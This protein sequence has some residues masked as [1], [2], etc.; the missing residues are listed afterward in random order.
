MEKEEIVRMFQT[1]NR[2]ICCPKCGAKYTFDNIKIVNSEDNL[3]FVS[4][5]C[6]DHPPVLAS[7]VI[8]QGKANDSIKQAEITPDDVIK[9][10]IGLRKVKSIKDLIYRKKTRR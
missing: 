8:Y 5:R 3:F 1:I 9:S 7:V 10:Y 6:D 4:L 2:N